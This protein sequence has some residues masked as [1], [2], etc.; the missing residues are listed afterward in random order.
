MHHLKK[1][2]RAMIDELTFQEGRL[3]ANTPT[4]KVGNKLN[5]DTLLSAIPWAT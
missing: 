4:M 5:D 2:Y 3:Y 1:D